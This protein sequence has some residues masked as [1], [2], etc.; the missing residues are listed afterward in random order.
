MITWK[1]GVG[2]KKKNGKKKKV[3][4]KKK[5]VGNSLVLKIVHCKLRKTR[6]TK[7]MLNLVNMNIT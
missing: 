4:K 2:K 6:W 5:N 1:L 3:G 7:Y